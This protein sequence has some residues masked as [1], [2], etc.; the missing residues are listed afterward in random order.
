M[1]ADELAF[2]D[3]KVEILD[4][5]QRL[6]AGVGKALREARELQVPRVQGRIA[7]P[8]GCRRLPAHGDQSLSRGFHAAARA[9]RLPG[10]RR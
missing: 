8:P 6:A 3:L 9:R 10:P 7:G 1:R 4:H 2:R 5:R